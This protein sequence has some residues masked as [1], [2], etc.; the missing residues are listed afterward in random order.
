MS[1]AQNHEIITSGFEAR[2][3][4]EGVVENILKE[5]VTL[6]AQMAWDIKSSNMQLMG[7]KKYKVLLKA[8]YLSEVTREAR[9]IVASEKFT[10][11]TIAM[12]L[13]AESTGHRIV[14]NFFLTINKPVTKTALFTDQEK[15]MNWLREQG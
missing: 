5:G 4:E 15:A 1:A 13:M 7:G 9:E 2:I 10:M 12:A 6:D 14:G 11:D 8:H 3:L